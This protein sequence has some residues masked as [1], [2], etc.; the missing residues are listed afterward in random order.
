[1][2]AFAVVVLSTSCMIRLDS[3]K[4]EAS[5][6]SAGRSGRVLRPSGV[7]VSRDTAVASFS[8][9]RVSGA[10]DVD[11]VQSPGRSEVRIYASDNIIQYVKVKSVGGVL[12]IETA[13]PKNVRQIGDVDINVTV[14][15]PDLSS[16]DISGASD[17]ECPALAVGD[18][19]FTI[20]CSGASDIEIKNL[21]S[22][23]LEVDMSG[24]SN[25]DVD[26][27]VTGDVSIN[28][29]GASDVELEDISA[30]NVSAVL[31]GASVLSLSG[32]AESAEYAASGASKVDACELHCPVSSVKSSGA[33][34][35]RYRDAAGNIR[36]K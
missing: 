6:T 32:K 18:K 31:S 29:S 17:F 35:V 30:G 24:A 23:S 7:Y 28:V 36:K 15:A 20:V 14:S 4:L 10:V 3:K 11:F 21:S 34:S 8:T 2:A 25:L 12:T 22:S 9:I 13:Y 26:R 33:S 5:V 19:K 16:V 1:M 27:A